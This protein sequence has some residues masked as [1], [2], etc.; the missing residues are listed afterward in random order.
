MANRRVLFTALMPLL[1]LLGLMLSFRLLSS[2]SNRDSE[3]LPTIMPSLPSR[4][5]YK[6]HPADATMQALLMEKVGGQLKAIRANDWTAAQTFSA[7]PFRQRVSPADFEK[8]IAKTYT[9]MQNWVRLR[10]TTGF[11]T[12]ANSA[13]IVATL[14][15]KNGLRYSYHYTLAKEGDTWCVDS[16]TPVDPPLATPKPGQT[17]APPSSPTQPPL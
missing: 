11:V 2:V 4:P 8:M 12:G 9:A 13:D 6:P 17:N 15:Q 16:C 10:Y 1:L 5:R 3:S 14:T 7:A